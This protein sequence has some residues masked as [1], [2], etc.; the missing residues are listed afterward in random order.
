M[1]L[2]AIAAAEVLFWVL[3]LAGL[4]T[5]YALKAPRVGASL[6]IATPLVDL[7]LLVL[8]YIDLST[9]KSSNFVHGLSALYIGY[10]IALGPTIIRALDMRIGRRFGKREVN[11]SDSEVRNYEAAMSTWKRACLASLISVVL[12]GAG[13]L[14]TGLQGS[15]WLIYWAIV[16]VFTV[17]MWW[18]I[19]PYRE[20]K[21]ERGHSMKAAKTDNASVSA[22]CTPRQSAEDE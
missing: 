6:L 16:A 17:A 10:S 12:L 21:K 9:G 5:R 14:I 2:I 11:N 7:A 20:K 1:I 19:G 15:F 22:N 18:Y 13:V 4:L 8:T 3:L